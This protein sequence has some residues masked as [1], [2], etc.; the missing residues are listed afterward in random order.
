[1]TR[2]KAGVRYMFSAATRWLVISVLYVFKKK[3][4]PQKQGNASF[5]K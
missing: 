5:S 4:L 1:M 2:L 3:L